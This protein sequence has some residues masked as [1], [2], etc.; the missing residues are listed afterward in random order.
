[1]NFFGTISR[2]VAAV[3]I[4]WLGALAVPTGTA[5]SVSIK[6]V[7]GNPSAG[8]PVEFGPSGVTAA[9]AFTWDFGDGSM[10]TE[11]S[12]R[13]V[14]KTPGSYPVTLTV[15]NDG[16]SISTSA[17]IQVA[18]STTLQL[19]AGAG[20]T[21]DVTLLAHNPNPSN[22]LPLTDDGE[23]IPQNDVF[24][25]FT[26]PHLVP[27]PAGA[28]IVPEVFVKILDARPIGQDFWVFW[29]G[30]TSFEYDLTVR[31]S[32]RGT[33]KVYHN[34]S[35]GSPPC[36]ATGNLSCRGFDTSG[37]ANGATPT[38]TAPGGNV[39]PTPTP[40]AATT[41][42]VKIGQGGN[43]F[44]DNES[45][46]STTTIHVGDT[47][48]WEWVS[49]FHSTTSGVCCT[50]DGKW[51]SGQHSPDH[52]FTHTFNQT[53]SFPYF[54]TVH[55]SSMTG[56]VSVLAPGATQ[57]APPGQPTNTPTEVPTRGGGY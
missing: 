12:P 11:R 1:M 15:R 33:V 9:D 14:Y 39:T 57:T 5:S 8:Q 37:F 24:G 22:G 48:R 30:L 31:D 4:S 28:P 26:L 50:G 56:T 13:H 44:I 36:L 47:V 27:I 51:E 46:N 43:N 16:A 55:G 45:G 2:V 29:G 25:Y 32:V 7:N 41:R 17:V 38:A 53:G 23:A 35:A 54:C 49:G 52:E 18:E 21:F 6:V 40:P 19:L 3:A 10:A 42:E 20:H 34:P